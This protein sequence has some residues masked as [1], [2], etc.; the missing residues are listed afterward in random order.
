MLCAR[1]GRQRFR[2]YQTL[3]L[4]NA[5]GRVRSGVL[6]ACRAYCAMRTTYTLHIYADAPSRLTDARSYLKFIDHAVV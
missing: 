6:Y 5:G 2:F 1:V 4:F 3:S